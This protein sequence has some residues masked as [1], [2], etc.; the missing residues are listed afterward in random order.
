MLRRPSHTVSL[1]GAACEMMRVVQLMVPVTHWVPEVLLFSCCQSYNED[2]EDVAVEISS[3]DG[4]QPFSPGGTGAAVLAGKG[5][6]RGR[7]RR[8]GAKR[9]RG[10][11]RRGGRGRGGAAAERRLS[12][13]G[14]GLRGWAGQKRPLVKEEDESEEEQEEEEEDDWEDELP[15]EE[16]IWCYWGGLESRWVSLGTKGRGIWQGTSQLFGS[17]CCRGEE[18]AVWDGIR[19]VPTPAAQWA[20]QGQRQQHGSTRWPGCQHSCSW[21]G[22]PDDQLTSTACHLNA[23]SAHPPYG[24]SLCTRTCDIR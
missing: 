21:W 13:S 9:G 14:G 1:A 15:G 11:G 17:G 22:H 7:G 3:D 2:V 6:G 23:Q 12:D 10:R 19:A 4:D 24:L 16:S 8:G 5:A 20:R 18:A